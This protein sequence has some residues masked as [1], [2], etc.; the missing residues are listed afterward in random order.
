MF[1]GPVR[2][3]FALALL[4]TAL[5]AGALV[6]TADARGGRHGSNHAAR[7]HA[8]R[9]NHHPA[10][11]RHRKACKANRRHRGA[12]ARCARKHK[13][14]SRHRMGRLPIGSRRVDPG[15]RT[16]P[17]RSNPAT[18]K[19]AGP[20][21]G[22]PKSPAF[23]P[24]P[25][26]PTTPTFPPQPVPAPA[27]PPISPP[28]VASGDLTVGLVSGAGLVTDA[29]FAAQLGASYVRVEFDINSSTSQIAPTIERY[30][31]SGAR[32]LL[33]AGFYG[34]IPSTGEAQN[35]ASW[36]RAFGPG[37]TFWAGRSDGALA[38]REI[39]FGNETNQ[40]Y[41]F[42]GCSWNCSGYIP[43]AEGYARALET[44]QVA[45]DSSGGDSGVGLLAIGD[46]G[47]TGSANWV[48]GMFNAV[49]DLGSRIVG[50]TTHAYGPKSRWQPLVNRLISETQARGAS[51]S[52]PIYVTEFGLASDNGGCLNNNYGW[53][54]CMTYSEAASVLHSD[55]N[56][57]LATYGS[58]IQALMLYQ[59]RDQQPGGTSDSEYYF[60]ALTNDGASK[61]AYTTEVRSQLAA[62]PA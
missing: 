36:A 16:P 4:M 35:L 49:P 9:G 59:V 11:T 41:Q 7:H 22:A 57:F 58:R 62:H 46:D 8:A 2:K 32:V 52:L 50:W 37:G 39:E 14:T 53:N 40:S 61:G 31:N 42:G 43:R 17:G 29:G 56:E 12:H 26:K 3:G 48:N 25:P 24:T 55:V 28:P 5:C 60:G 33:L 30:A 1:H 27:P 34:R 21:S 15:S 47:G 6:A 10:S 54:P 51:S 13:P 38:V 18:P 45:I 20:K 44:A 19:P 23:K